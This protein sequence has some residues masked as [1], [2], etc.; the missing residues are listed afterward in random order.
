MTAPR[1]LGGRR[2]SAQTAEKPVSFRDTACANSY[3]YWLVRIAKRS[4]VFDGFGSKPSAAQT[5]RLATSC[6]GG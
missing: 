1:S 5:P 4:S 2:T 3:G 6:S